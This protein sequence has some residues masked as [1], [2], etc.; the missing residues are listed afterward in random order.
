MVELLH[1]CKFVHTNK[2]D[3]K[4]TTN[5]MEDII[6]T[7]TTNLI[8]N[9]D[10]AFCATVNIA[11]YLVIKAIIDCTNSDK[12]NTWIKRLVFIIVSLI[13]ASIYWLAGSDIKVIFNSFIIAPVSWSWIFKPICNKLN[14]DYKSNSI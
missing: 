12:I 7:I 14:I 6:T 5:N 1:F 2:R 9:F 3:I 4:N 11:T 8:T 13:I 10:F